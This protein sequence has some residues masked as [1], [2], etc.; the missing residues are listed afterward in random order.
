[1]LKLG[2]DV[3]GTFTDLCLLDAGS[4]RVWIEK[5]PSTP[6]DQSEAF[7]DGIFRVLE[8]AGRDRGDV[9]FLV[10]GTTVATNA[11]L[12]RKGARTALLTTAGF[13]DVLE[14]GTQQRRELYSVIQTRPPALVPRELRLDVP[15]RV[16]ADGAVV[17]PLDEPAARAA[18][19]RLAEQDVESLA[20][21][22]LFSFMNTAHERRLGELAAELLPGAMVSLSSQISP[23]YREYWRMS[24]TAVNAYVMPPVFRYIDRLERRL[25]ECG[26]AARLHVMQSSG[27]LMTATTTKERPVMTILSGPVGGVIGGTFF[28]SLAGFEDVVTF[29]MGGTS[30][31]VATVVGAEPGRVHLK[32]HEGYPLRTPMID[33][34]TI[35][36]GG[37][38]I[39]RVD[40][41]GGLKVGPESAAAVPGPACY[42]RG[43]AAATVTDADLVLG[44]L[45][46]GAVLGRDV[47]LDV[48]R[49]RDVVTRDVAA[50][51]GLTVEEAAAGIVAIA[52]A[53]MRAA[54]RTITVQKGLDPRDFALVAFG[55]AGPMHACAV[56]RE[57]GIPW[58]VVPPH[59][60]IT[61]AVGLLMSDIR[62]PMAAPF[63]TPAATADLGA[64]EARFAE[65]R[66]EAERKLLEDGVP[67]E[68]ITFRRSVDMR[69]QGQ[70]YEL[71]I[72]CG[73]PLDGGPSE[74]GAT[75]LARL[76]ARFHERHER[77]YGHHADDEPTQ[78]VNLRVEGIG[79]VPRGAWREFVA[80]G[81]DRRRARRVFTGGGGWTT[82][83]VLDRGRLG[84]DEVYRGPLVVEQLDTTVWIPPGDSARVDAHGNLVV[85]IAR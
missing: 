48:A 53:N 5:L 54:I 79:A 16:A 1:M 76:V 3:G 73:E 85:E 6:A 57:T 51:L 4:G 80:P 28:G 58:V 60:G 83:P 34:E 64:A 62:H 55:G 59:P 38:S 24:T 26:V 47:H 81:D 49:A 61:S 9:D 36:A 82:T 22:L 40:A 65:L 41:G 35:G 45:G 21:C 67:P 29:D 7:V 43:G 50:P 39:A 52:N 12:E 72:D 84:Q 25:C 10:H 77:V 56:A 42:G 37:G 46:D 18:L 33:I 23:E 78:F 31:D 15:E 8:R 27:G 32:E 20:I 71:T 2:V 11:L 44:V 69:Y 75:P 70:A 63:I 68:A 66:G 19:A 13:R 14:I 17:Q 30:C 74:E